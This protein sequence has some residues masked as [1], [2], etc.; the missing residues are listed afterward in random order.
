MHGITSHFTISSHNLLT[1]CAHKKF[2]VFHTLSDKF[3]ACSYG[4]IA[5]VLWNAVYRIKIG[6]VA[7]VHQIPKFSERGVGKYWALTR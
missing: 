2:T 1:H 5:T 7:H 3:P 6:S 4:Y